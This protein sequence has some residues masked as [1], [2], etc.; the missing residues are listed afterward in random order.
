MRRSRA[1][2]YMNESLSNPGGTIPAGARLRRHSAPV[3]TAGDIQPPYG[4]TLTNLLADAARAADLKRQSKEWLSWD[5]TPRQLCD[6]ELLLNGGFSPLRGFLGPTDYDRVCREMRLTNGTLWPIPVMLDVSE[7]FASK[8]DAGAKVALRDPEGLLM[9]ILTVRE[10]W[11]PDRMAEAESVYGTANRQHV[12][13]KFLMDEVGPMYVGGEVEG[14]QL[15]QYHDFQDLRHT[16]A[17]LREEFH[18]RG[19]RKVIAFQTRNP[20]HRAHFEMTLQ[21][22]NERGANLLIH[23]TTGMTKPGDVDHFCRVRCYQALLPRYPENLATLSLLPL[24][25]RMA[26]PREAVWHAIIRRNYGC[27]HLIV[28]RDHAGPGN[29]GQGRPFYEPFAGQE[30]VLKH[31]AELGI[32]TVPFA[33]MVYCPTRQEHLPFTQIAPGA[34]PLELSGTEL[35]DLL[36]EGSEIPEWFTFPEVAAELRKTYPPRSQQGFTIFF[37]GLSGSGKSTLAKALLDKLLEIG[38]RPVT[39]L[40]GDIVRKNLSSELGFSREHRNLNILRI[41]FVA[42]EITKNR[43]VA[44]CA[45]IAPYEDIRQQVR[46]LISPRGGFILV[47]LSTP[48]EL[49]EQRDRKGLYAKARAGI[50]KEFTGVSDPYEAPTDAEVVLNTAELSVEDGCQ[51]ILNYLRQQGYLALPHR[52]CTSI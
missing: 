9:A 33:T 22:A 7:S 4:G 42:N 19:W 31:E 45:P 52:I 44:I 18:R 51:A 21:A 35:R 24:S 50:V 6:L 49:C 46:K 40:D 38:G 37:T 29:N 30:L 17:Q 5:L 2:K 16:P 8:L 23:P 20:M 14:L 10:V 1:A 32:G 3:E 34:K 36:A 43:G 25:M 15:P 11:R 12:G 27:S 41:G 26:G 39:L 28:G 48:L 47:Y 13:A